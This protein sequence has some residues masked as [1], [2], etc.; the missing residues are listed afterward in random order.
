M[1]RRSWR[2]TRASRAA[3]R[4]KTRRPRCSSFV[5]APP[6]AAP[7]AQHQI[8]PGG[9][10]TGRVRGGEGR[11]CFSP[12]VLVA[13]RSPGRPL[14]APG[15][16][17][18]ITME[19]LLRSSCARQ[20]RPPC[21][22]RKPSA[23]PRQ[24]HP[25]ARE[26][27]P[28][29]AETTRRLAPHPQLRADR[30][31]RPGPRARLLLQDRATAVPREQLLPAGLGGVR[32]ALDPERT[33]TFEQLGMPVDVCNRICNIASGLVPLRGSPAR[34]STSLA[35]MIDHIN[36]TRATTSS[37]SRIPSSSCEHK[38]CMVTQREVGD[39]TRG[40]NALKSVLRQDP[41]IAGG[42]PGITRPS[43][44][45]SRRPGTSRSTP[46]TSDA[47][48]TVNR[49]IDVFPR[50]SRPGADH[51]RHARGRLLS[52]AAADGAREGRARGGDHAGDAGNPRAHPRRQGSPD[53][54]AHPDRRAAG[55][56]HHVPVAREAISRAPCA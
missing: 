33:P 45:R 21:L 37:R 30:A 3:G 14:T 42:E 38:Q 49:I 11:R 36:E 46:P 52:E 35:A 48:Q 51:A 9:G 53:L 56:D 28:L 13:D 1:I 27:A 4:R 8:F 34:P 17:P 26:T 18:M 12:S 44:P 29:D 43:R 19:E 40:L 25:A 5:D 20:L 24:R 55:H 2:A 50:I 7:G 22:G 47:V 15:S 32:A 31:P 39:D 23:Y 6:A 10:G 41:D 54:L 16:A